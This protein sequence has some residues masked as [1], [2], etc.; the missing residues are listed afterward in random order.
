V[1]GM[2]SGV[3]AAMDQIIIDNGDN[4]ENSPNGASASGLVC[5]QKE[6]TLNIFFN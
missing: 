2:K 5:K 1:G 6:D 3:W 4:Y